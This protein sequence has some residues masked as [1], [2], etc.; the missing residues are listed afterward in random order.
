MKSCI[1]KIFIFARE[2]PLEHRL[3]STGQRTPT[4]EYT[5]TTMPGIAVPGALELPD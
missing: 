2:T 1:K 5:T 4:E 3:Y